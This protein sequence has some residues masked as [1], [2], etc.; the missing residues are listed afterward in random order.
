MRSCKCDSAKAKEQ[1]CEDATTKREDVMP[2]MRRC[3]GRRSDTSIAPSQLCTLAFAS[4]HFRRRLFWLHSA[5]LGRLH[6]ILY[7]HRT[8]QGFQI[9][10]CYYWYA[11]AR[12]SRLLWMFIN[13]LM[14]K[15]NIYIY[16][17]WLCLIII[18]STLNVMSAI[19]CTY[20]LPD[21]GLSLTSR[22]FTVDQTQ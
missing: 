4:S 11:C 21:S 5:S 19:M 3:E 2:K 8:R 10:P 9:N 6:R 14:C 20:A 16:Q 22:L 17:C 7:R 13:I 1:K 18:Y 12:P 15:C